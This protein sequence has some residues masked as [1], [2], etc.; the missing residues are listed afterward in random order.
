MKQQT[1]QDYEAHMNELMRQVLD[2]LDGESAH[3][4]VGI[5]FALVQSG[6]AQLP[7]KTRTHIRQWLIAYLVSNGD[8]VEVEEAPPQPQVH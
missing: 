2:L 4:V 7:A 8:L 6:N 1:R 5:G 3:D